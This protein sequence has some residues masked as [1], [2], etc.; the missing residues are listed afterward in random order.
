MPSSLALIDFLI[1]F[2]AFLFLF[3]ILAV[4]AAIWMMKHNIKIRK[5]IHENTE[6]AYLE[7][8]FEDHKQYF[9]SIRLRNSQLVKIK[10]NKYCFLH[11]VPMNEMK[12]SILDDKLLFYEQNVV[13]PDD[14]DTDEE[15][16]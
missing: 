15:L 6:I 4:I 9:L 11:V 2:F 1:F 5:Y 10:V 3:S 14:L 8:K 16:L 13:L 7:D 12:V